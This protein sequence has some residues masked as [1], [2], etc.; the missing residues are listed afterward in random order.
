MPLAPTAPVQGQTKKALWDYHK[1]LGLTDKQIAE[2]KTTVSELNAFVR[3]Q[4]ERLKP[5]EAQLNDQIR[6]DASIDLVRATMKQ[7]ADVQIEIRLA[8]VKSSR[9]I[10]AVLSAEQKKKWRDIQK[11]AREAA[12]PR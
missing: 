6:K 7:I 5:L 2:L 3:A 10:S 1:E 8:D 11:A 9:K 12:Q 4:Q